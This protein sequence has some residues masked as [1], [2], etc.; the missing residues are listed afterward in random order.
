MSLWLLVAGAFTPYGGM[1][2][3]NFALARYLARRSSQDEVHL[4]SHR[5]SAALTALPSVREHRVPRPLGAERFGEPLIRLATRRWQ[6][7]LSSTSN[8]HGVRTI[9]N[10]GN[11][12]AGDVNWGPLRPRGVPARGCRRLEPAARH[13]ESPPL[14]HTGA[15]GARALEGDHLQQPPDR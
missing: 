1:D 4:V 2:A 10:G 7:R 11:A 13:L 15:R 9:A 8:G 5:V 12:D 6:R 3:A 14:P